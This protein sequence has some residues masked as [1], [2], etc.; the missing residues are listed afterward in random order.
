[1]ERTGMKR[2]SMNGRLTTPALT[3]LAIFLAG[4][5]SGCPGS[6]GSGIGPGPTVVGPAVGGAGSLR[7]GAGSTSV[8]LAVKLDVIVPVFNPNL[9]KDP[10]DYEDEGIWPELRRA[11]ANRFAV[12]TKNALEKRGLLGSIRVT[13]NAKATG[14]LY[15]LGTVKE[16]NGEDIE[17]GIKVVDIASRTWHSK[18]YSHR[19]KEYFFK[20]LRNKGKDPYAPIFEEIAE[21]VIALLRRKKAAELVELRQIAELRFASSFAPEAFQGYL[22]EGFFGNRIKV[23]ALPSEDDQLLARIRAIRVQDELFLDNMQSEYEAFTGRMDESYADWQ[24]HSL[25]WVKAK[26]KA[27]NAAI[28]KFL[29]G[30]ALAITAVAASRN[31]NVQLAGVAAGAAFAYSA[32]KSNGEAKVYAEELDELGS[33]ID[34]NLAPQVVAFEGRTEKLTGNASEQYEQW[35]AFLKKIYLQ[36]AI[37]EKKL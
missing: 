8:P 37:P 27:R 34:V 32:Y 20:D 19:V 13:P 30:T 14:D 1:M 6:G 15:I 21:D 33:S 16:V 36:Q 9:P 22:K 35:Q 28:G 4:L 7:S 11:E 10:D 17:L 23:A 5:L 12:N 2:F 31:S 26:R 25:G 3:I 24:E 18:T 29:L